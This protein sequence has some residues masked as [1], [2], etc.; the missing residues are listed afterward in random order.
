[1]KNDENLFT[2]PKLFSLIQSD[3]E[4]IKMRKSMAEMSSYQSGQSNYSV[5]RPSSNDNS[6]YQTGGS[7]VSGTN[8]LDQKVM[9]ES[10]S[11]TDLKG[12]QIIR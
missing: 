3:L 8:K 5:N 4:E 10:S 7:Q 11:I 1:M 9:A 2:D 6:S 12:V